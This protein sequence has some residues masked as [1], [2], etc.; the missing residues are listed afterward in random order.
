MLTIDFN[1]RLFPVINPSQAGA[2]LLNVGQLA[3]GNP[4]NIPVQLSYDDQNMTITAQTLGPHMIV[5]V[6][7]WSVKETDCSIIIETQAWEQRNG[8]LN[9]AA[10]MLGGKN[11]MGSIWAQY[12]RNLADAAT[13]GNAAACDVGESW[14]TL[15]SGSRNP[16]TLSMPT[17]GPR[18][19]PPK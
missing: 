7:K 15:P 1:V 2:G 13:G 5:G 8:T 6:R 3:I 11:A 17:Q 18:L 4:I 9:N 12:L 19:V 16:F 14:S 10:M